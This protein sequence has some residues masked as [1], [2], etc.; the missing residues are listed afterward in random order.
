MCAY[1]IVCYSCMS[2]RFAV[3]ARRLNTADEECPPQFELSLSKHTHA[4]ISLLLPSSSS[5]HLSPSS[6]FLLPPSFSTLVFHCLSLYIYMY[7][8]CKESNAAH[9][10]KYEL[11]FHS[12]EV[13]GVRN[14]V[15]NWS[16]APSI[17]NPCEEMELVSLEVHSNL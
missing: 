15:I 11:H 3:R 7:T 10:M 1:L 6:I 2:V 9:S 14:A 16:G 8:L 5:R 4:S 12:T 17:P 13:L